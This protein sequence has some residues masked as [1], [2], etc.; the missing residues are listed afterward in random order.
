MLFHH[1]IGVGNGGQQ[2]LGVRM[3]RVGENLLL[4]AGENILLLLHLQHFCAGDFAHAN[5]LGQQQRYNHQTD[6]F[7]HKNRQH[8][9]DHQPRNTVGDFDE[10]LHD[11]VHTSTEVTG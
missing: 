1:G 8:G 4:A 9:H 10:A 6:A 2:T 11:A 7:G 5:P 3:N